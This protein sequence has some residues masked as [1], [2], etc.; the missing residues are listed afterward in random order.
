LLKSGFGL[1]Q[2]GAW[3]GTQL[4]LRAF[5][6]A[7]AYVVGDVCVL[8]YDNEAGKGDHRHIGAQQKPYRFTTPEE[9]LR[10]CWNDVDAWEPE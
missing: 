4:Q 6:Y 2:P 3:V 8:P 1:S 7:L 9:L 10:D 5:N